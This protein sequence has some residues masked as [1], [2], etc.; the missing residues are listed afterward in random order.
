MFSAPTPVNQTVENSVTWARSTASTMETML[1]VC[2][3]FL[4]LIPSHWII[5]ALAF[6]AGMYIMLFALGATAYRT[7]YLNK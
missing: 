2:R 3:S 1:G 7:L 4:D 6:A 5:V